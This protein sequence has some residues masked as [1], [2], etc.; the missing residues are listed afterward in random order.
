MMSSGHVTHQTLYKRWELLSATEPIANVATA[1]FA[2]MVHP[3]SPYKTTQDLMKA[4]KEKPGQISMATGGLG[5]PAHMCWEV[6]ASSLGGN[7]RVNHVPYKSGLESAQAVMANQV[8]FA[9]S[10]IG[11]AYPII[12]QKQARA[13]AITSR[14]RLK[15]LPDVPTIAETV[16]P[17]FEYLTLLF[18]AAGF[19][20]AAT[21][22]ARGGDQDHP[23]ARHHR[24]RVT[25]GDSGSA[26]R[27][28][29]SESWHR[30]SHRAAG[31]ARRL[32]GS[33]HV[34]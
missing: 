17:K 23:G 24:R 10:Y 4:I 2:Y 11:S 7:L 30:R 19:Q 14:E 8:D 27:R 18:Y 13:L 1:S 21:D 6:F 32:A 15:V 9:S 25:R 31:G 3:S 5:S 34:S 16:L 22:G 12:N 20:S 26:V 28:H 29:R 33:D